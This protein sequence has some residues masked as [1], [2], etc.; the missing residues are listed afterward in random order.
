M[1][2]P[3]LIVEQETIV[4]NVNLASN[5]DLIVVLLFNNIIIHQS[6]G[7]YPSLSL[8]LRCFSI[9]HTSRIIS[10]PKHYFYV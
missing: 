8:T 10:G 3:I 7:K 5:R 6:G 1:Y 4:G 9:Y 2:E